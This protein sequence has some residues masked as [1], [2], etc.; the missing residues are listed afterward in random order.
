[1]QSPK[2]RKNR[3]YLNG[4]FRGTS[5]FS[6][7]YRMCLETSDASIINILFTKQLAMTV[8]WWSSDKVPFCSINLSAKKITS[9]S[10]TKMSILDRSWPLKVASHVGTIWKGTLFCRHIN[11]DEKFI[12]EL[13]PDVISVGINT[14][15]TIHLGCPRDVF[16]HK[17]S[18]SALN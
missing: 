12:I 8:L 4:T 1:M 10:T 7:N 14:V 6:D 17:Y 15:E 9:H 13:C 3:A 5:L 11:G 2:H 16:C 18:R